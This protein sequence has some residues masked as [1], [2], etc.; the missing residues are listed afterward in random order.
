MH[1]EHL[2]CAR[3]S[4]QTVFD[5]AKVFEAYADAADTEDDGAGH[6][7][8]RLAPGFQQDESGY[9]QRGYRHRDGAGGSYMSSSFPPS[10]KQRS[11]DASYRSMRM[12]AATI[13]S[14]QGMERPWGQ[15]NTTAAYEVATWPMRSSTSRRGVHTWTARHSLRADFLPRGCS[16]RRASPR[17]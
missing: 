15:T 6:H 14:S 4:R 16:A 12:A 17:R 9:R 5:L 1:A 8:R 2:R 3:A 11:Q 7:H 13:H 10:L